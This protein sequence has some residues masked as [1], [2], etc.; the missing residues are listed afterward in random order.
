M[1]GTVYYSLIISLED[2]VR[3]LADLKLVHI[4]RGDAPEWMPHHKELEARWADGCMKIGCS[5]WPQPLG[6]SVKLCKAYL[7]EKEVY[8]SWKDSLSCI[9]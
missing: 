9:N 5:L 8:D 1:S 3:F 7:R 2:V 4:G 6:S